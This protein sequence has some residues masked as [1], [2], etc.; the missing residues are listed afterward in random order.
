MAANKENEQLAAKNFR[1]IPQELRR[2]DQWVV[3][4]LNKIPGRTKPTK[5]PYDPNNG[6]NSKSTDP[7]TWGSFDQAVEAFKSGLYAGIGF[8]FSVDDPYCGVDL[9][10]VIDLRTGVIDE[11]AQNIINKLDSYAEYSPSGTGV[12]IICKAK[13]P[14]GGRK[15]GNFEC[16]DEKRYFTFTGNRLTKTPNKI[17]ERQNEIEQFHHRIFGTKQSSKSD[18]NFHN[19]KINL[20]EQANPPKDKLAE[21]LQSKHCKDLW[22]KKRNLPSQSEY[23]LGLAIMAVSKGWSAQEIADLIIAHRKRHNEDLK[24]E[25][26]QKYQRTISKALETAEQFNQDSIQPIAEIE[27]LNANHA[28]VPIGGSVVILNESWD[29]V[30]DRPEITF[31]NPS[32]FKLRYSNKL[33]FGPRKQKPIHLGNY[34]LNHP[35][36]REYRGIVFEP[37]G[38]IDGYYNLFRGFPIEPKRGKHRLFKDFVLRVIC[39]SN[40]PLFEYVW[41]WLAHLFQK[42]YE[43][44]ETALVIRGKQGVGKNTFADAIGYLVGHHYL[45]LTN[46]NQLAGRF[47]SHL[48]DALLVFANEAVWG[49]EKSNEGTLKAMITDQY[50]PV[51]HKGKDIFMV[52]N[53]KHLIVGSN[54]S[55]AVPMGLDDRRF[56]VLDVSDRYKEDQNYFK[57]IREELKT[58]GYKALITLS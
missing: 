8:V 43:L 16:Y 50:S 52:K 38:T 34:W 10:D 2:Y 17:K 24:L 18:G 47:N 56:V 5:V 51:E 41:K 45:C 22:E 3:W 33:I 46:M 23:D 32:S 49:G 4:K 30:F 9:D 26:R 31:S 1:A 55:W 20:D 36:R 37:R 25:N 13:L 21:L 57:A 42:P 53:Y 44:P 19:I 27:D 15:K 58:G 40:K 7:R 28:V 11:D 35:N 54:E 14:V 39:A 6:K 12:H 48:K 29:P